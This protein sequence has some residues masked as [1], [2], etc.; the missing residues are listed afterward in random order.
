M[1]WMLTMSLEIQTQ[2]CMSSTLYMVESNLGYFVDI[3]F[4]I[5]ISLKGSFL[6]FYLLL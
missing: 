2:F 5:N 6:K 1:V 4:D 3:Y